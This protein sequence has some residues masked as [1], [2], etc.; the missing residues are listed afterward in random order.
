MEGL[1]KKLEAGVVPHYM[2][3]HSMGALASTN[4]FG[5]VL[6]LKKTL[7]LML[8]LLSSAKADNI[9]QAF[10]YGIYSS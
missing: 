2:I 3:P 4:P 1:F 9:R 6:Y 7:A 5:V 8:P 10:A